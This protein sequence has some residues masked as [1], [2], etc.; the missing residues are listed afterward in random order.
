M[1]KGKEKE[2]VFCEAVGQEV[3]KSYRCPD[4]E[5][6][7]DCNE[8]KLKSK[9]KKPY[10]KRKGLKLDTK[11]LPLNEWDTLIKRYP[12]FKRH[13]ISEK[14]STN[15]K[16]DDIWGNCLKEKG[17]T[18]FERC[19]ECEKRDKKKQRA[20][21]HPKNLFKD[22]T[23]VTFSEWL[24][25]GQTSPTFLH[26]LKNFKD[27]FLKDRRVNESHILRLLIHAYKT[28]GME[29]FNRTL[30]KLK[31]HIVLANIYKAKGEEGLKETIPLNMSDIS[32]EAT[33]S[34][35][36]G[37]PDIDGDIEDTKKELEVIIDAW[38]VGEM[39]LT[40]KD[41][42]A[43]PTYWTKKY[44]SIITLI[45]GNPSVISLPFVNK[46]L[47]SLIKCYNTA[48]R[49]STTLKKI[50]KI[51]EDILPSRRGGNIPYPLEEIQY[52]LELAKR[53]GYTKKEAIKVISQELGISF[54]KL[55]QKPR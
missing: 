46:A 7:E 20:R 8:L 9:P 18:T 6:C 55:K 5:R 1:G 49:G 19:L 41:F 24:D 29:G 12:C 14:Q 11:V 33:I 35:F 42:E 47:I 4:I 25:R 26:H 37:I 34:Y 38:S 15:L 40:I 36:R 22:K 32:V 23:G 27:G 39:E 50:K 28:N 54:S 21:K 53:E 30:N 10:K 45:H 2:I 44:N 3:N 51:W 17:K 48:D 13:Q 52:L 31:T 16:A 43:R